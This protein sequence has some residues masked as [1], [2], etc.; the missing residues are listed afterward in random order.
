MIATPR[1]QFQSAISLLDSILLLILST[2]LLIYQTCKEKIK[3]K[4]KKGKVILVLR[5]CYQIV[6]SVFHI[7][8]PDSREIY[9]YSEHRQGFILVTTKKFDKYGAI[10]IIKSIKMFQFDLMIKFTQPVKALVSFGRAFFG[11]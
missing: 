5:N 7:E 4:F 11:T 3:V 1:L 9:H 8:Y 10:L 2:L 6:V